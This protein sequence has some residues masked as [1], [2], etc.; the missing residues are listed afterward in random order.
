MQPLANYIEIKTPKSQSLTTKKYEICEA[1][2]E[3]YGSFNSTPREA[4]WS[5]VENEIEE[6]WFPSKD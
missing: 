3:Q 6:P 2:S 5:D 1:L 4:T